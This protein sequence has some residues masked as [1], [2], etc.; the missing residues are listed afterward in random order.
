[1]RN[2]RP[3]D[4]A[5]VFLM[6]HRHI[7]TSAVLL[8][9]FAPAFAPAAET[10]PKLF[11]SFQARWIGPANMSGRICDVA[12]AEGKP[13]IMY[14]A[15]ASGGLWKTVNH[16]TTWTPLF[17][18]QDVASIGAVAVSPAD[19]SIVW[20]GT[21]EA[22]P[23]NSVSWGNGV[24]M[25]S[26]GGKT[27]S[28]LGLGGSHHVGRIVIH[29]KNTAVVFV[30]ALGHVWGPNRQRGL[31]KTDDGGKSWKQALYIDP[32]TGCID[33]AVDP[34]DP[35]IVYAAMW[36]V[37]RDGF[38][39]GNPAVQTGPGSG[40]YRSEDGGKNWTRM[41]GGLPDRPLGRC[42][43]AVW[44]K[45]PKVLYA[46]VQTDTTVATTVGQPAKQGNNAA[47]GGI[48]RSADKGKTWTKLNDLCPRPFYYGQ[49]RVD[50]TDDRR[51]YVLGIQ[52][53]V[54]SDGGKT[55]RS[56]GAAGGVHAD[57]H[58]L[59]IDPH[60]PDHL[61][62]GNDGGLYFSF[63][64]GAN[65]QHAKNLPVA[66]FYGVAADM[67]KPYRVY[68]G[69]QD[70]GTWGGPSATHS[71]EGI[72]LADWSR[73]LAAD[74]FQCQVDPTDSDI[75]YA[76]SQYGRLRRLNVRTG[77]Q[78][79]IKP[80]PP[81][82]A[83]EYRFNWNSP[84]LLSPHNP[85]TL[86]YGGNHLF[87]SVNRGDRWEVISP[88]LTR[89][90]PGPSASTGHTISTVGES[91][92]RPGVLYGGTDD[93]RVHV[94]RN[95]GA[96]WTERSD[97]LADVPPERW[98]TRIECS[99][100][101]EGT[102]YLALDRHR[103]D[104]RAPYLFKTTDFG[105]T[106]QSIGE[107]L[108]HGGPVH[109]IREDP[110]NPDLLFAGTEF[111]LFVSLDGGQHWRRL[112]HG[113]PTVAVHDLVIHPRDRELVVATHGRG[114]FVMDIV[115]LQELTAKVL[116]QDAYLCTVKPATVF[117]PRGFRGLS[118]GGF[119]TGLNPRYGA[120]VW[121]YFKGRAPEGTSLTVTDALGKTVIDLAVERT[122]G[123][124]RVEWSL[125]S[126][127]RRDGPAPPTAPGEY[128][129]RLK[130]GD[131]ELTRRVKVES[132]ETAAPAGTTGSK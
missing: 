50:P 26:D 73:V 110:R 116:D 120:A 52:M 13:A 24:H 2:L 123:L 127:N 89:G 80:V 79:V 112:R 32:D 36:Q 40:L 56:D 94:S 55:F 92:L 22:N 45:D 63:D 20:V 54:S 41:T 14:V 21:G 88:D 70:N 93:G 30:A 108:P 129:V 62:L 37:R 9:F 58:A 35:D 99:H 68:G 6:P 115:P 118:G 17:D 95:G 10:D 90:K 61:V 86:Y 16:G 33:V 83:P 81:A 76:E 82:G 47:S 85:R 130:I 49:I 87:R 19:A 1:M 66:Q 109:V 46:V 15:T 28:F 91:P 106:W 78:T 74:G 64:R 11:D 3:P 51:I 4:D 75:I 102:A 7:C 97:K 96:D 98:I 71:L 105:A 5:R 44:A 107:E 8:L 111:G 59:W 113:L 128:I 114:I 117:E 103:N 84:V 104:D 25:S 48:F 124:H 132:A 72:T 67:R 38:S 43:L 122:A 65:W 39:G 29:P 126:G 12:V 60:D 131:K 119:A 77:E 34:T 100:F 31:F 125:R 57:H 53:H 18:D 42:G 23:R 101:A 27:W 121:Y 69:L